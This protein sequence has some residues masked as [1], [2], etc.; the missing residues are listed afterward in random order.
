[1]SARPLLAEQ[2]RVV[3]VP[4]RPLGETCWAPSAR[5]KGRVTA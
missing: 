3:Y 4:M 2:P 5:R 1:M